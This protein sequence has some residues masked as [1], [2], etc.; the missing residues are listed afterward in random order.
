MGYYDDGE[1]EAPVKETGGAG[2]AVRLF[3]GAAI[4]MVIILCALFFGAKYLN[5]LAPA[6]NTTF[7]ATAFNAKAQSWGT[8]FFSNLSGLRHANYT[9]CPALTT[10]A[11]KRFS[12]MVSDY[13]ISHF[14]FAN[15]FSSAGFGSI[16]LEEEYFFPNLFSPPGYFAASLSHDAPVH[17][18]GLMNATYTYYGFYMHYGSAVVDSGGNPL[19][20]TQSGSEINS[21]GVN[22]TQFLKSKGC[23]VEVEN[24]T[25][26]VLEVAHSCP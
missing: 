26:F 7:N 23:N 24:E 18:S 4:L 5:R 12:T 25:W 14:G 20:C 21:T 3:G 11:Q 6:T 8:L 15:D 13:Q 17:F 22:V 2:E 16:G 19:S 9:Y 10:F 1:I